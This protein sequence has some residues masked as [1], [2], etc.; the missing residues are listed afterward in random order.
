MIIL[1]VKEYFWLIS[2]VLLQLRILFLQINMQ[3]NSLK[4]QISDTMVIIKVHVHV[5]V[6]RVSR[7]SICSNKDT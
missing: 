2:L 5:H 1:M 4:D 6:Y 3:K 7:F